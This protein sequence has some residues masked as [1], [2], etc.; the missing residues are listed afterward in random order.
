MKTFSWLQVTFGDPPLE[1]FSKNVDFSLWGKQ[2]IVLP[3]WIF[4]RVL[5]HCVLYI[6]KKDLAYKFRLW[7]NHLVLT[8]VVVVASWEHTL[9]VVL[10]IG[11]KIMRFLVRLTYMWLLGWAQTVW[12]SNM[13]GSRYAFF[14]HNYCI[15]N[16]NRWYIITNKI[17]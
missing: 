3:K 2:Y 9:E 5:A 6:Y 15:W 17:L 10:P 12:N 4:F 16:D 1:I 11:R 8:W 13:F 14:L 7:S